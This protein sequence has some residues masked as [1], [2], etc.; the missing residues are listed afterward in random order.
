[1]YRVIIAIAVCFFTFIL[2]VIYLANTG[3]H[4]IFFDFVRT[5]PYG[6]KLGHAGLFG[7]LTLLVVIGSKFRTFICGKINIY[8]GALLVVIFVVGEEVSQAFIPSRTFDLVD[9]A[10]DSVGIILAINF[11]YLIR[12]YF[13]KSSKNTPKTDVL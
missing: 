6:D 3:G 12:K 1:M 10:A 2:W 11:S 4:S 9:L 7:F 13:L 5:I 8:Y